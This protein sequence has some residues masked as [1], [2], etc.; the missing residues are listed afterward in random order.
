MLL[1]GWIS[2][3]FWIAVVGAVLRLGR[4]ADGALKRSPATITQSRSRTAI[5]FPIYHEEPEDLVAGVRAI[6]TSITDAGAA[7]HFDIY[8]LSDSSD[9][10]VREAEQA[11][12]L[13]ARTDLEDAAP[14]Y[15][16]NRASN[17]GRKSGNIEDFCRNWGALYDYMVV[18]D[19]DSLMSGET[20]AELVRLMDANPLTALI[21]VPPALVGRDTVFARVQQFAS[22]LYGPIYAAGLA[23]LFGPDGNYWGHN[24]IIRVRAFTENCGLPQLPGKPPLGGEIM[25]HD[26][27]EAALLRRAG[28]E[29]RLMP[30][31]GGSY[32]EPPPTILDH[33]LRDRRW[34]QGNLQHLPLIFAKGFRFSSRMHLVSGVMSYLAQPLWLAMLIVSA[35]VAYDEAQMPVVTYIGRYPLLGWPV[36]HELEVIELIATATVMLF[37]HKILALLVL[38]AD[39]ESRAAYGGITRAS[40]SV[41]FES[42]FSILYAPIAMLSHCWFVLSTFCGISVG[43]ARQRRREHCPRLG[44]VLASFGPH[45][46][47]GILAALALAP[48]FPIGPGGSRLCLPARSFPSRSVSS[49]AAPRSDARCAAGA[50]SSFPARIHRRECCRYLRHRRV[51]RTGAD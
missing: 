21:Q 44:T 51:R 30:S 41:V 16:R 24:A 47:I 50:C 3:S 9:P 32:E 25:S 40:L 45:T 23:F 4:N 13:R 34:C 19:A 1:F 36:S 7:G 31:L 49:R 48:G 15:Y 14:L 8:L 12:F 20:L 11:T 5:L 6:G 43:W 35:F 17:T 2:A 18:L 33:L 38:F 29:V 39:R 27:V 10:E 46:V 28:W 42:V 37:G 22:N 26:F